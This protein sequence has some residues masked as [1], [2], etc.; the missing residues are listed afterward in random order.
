MDRPQGRLVAL[1]AAALI[2]T[3]TY[4]TT[5]FGL[6]VSVIIARSL[7]PKD[8]GQYA[9][10]LWMSGLLVV[11]GNHGLGIS[12]IRFVSESLGR[13]NPDEARNIHGWLRRQ[14]WISIMVVLVC[15]S[16][17]VLAFHPAGWQEHLALLIGVC[18]VSAIGKA[19]FLFDISIAKGYSRFSVEAVTNMVMSLLYTTG[20]AL[21]GLLHAS[22]TVFALFFALISAG[23]VVMVSRLLRKE[24][25]APGH[26]VCEPQVLARL[27]PHLLWTIVLVL[28]AT[29]SNKTIETFLLSTLIG[30]AAVGF[31]SIATALTRGGIDLLSSTLTTMLMPMMGHAY[32]A[33][34]MRKVNDIL[35]DAV[36]YFLFVGLIVAGLGVLWA[37]LGVSVMYGSRYEPVI[38]VLRVMM[39]V[40]GLTLAESAFGALLSTTDHQ[41]LRAGVSMLS[42]V[43]SAI[44]SLILVPLYGL[45]G[46]VLAHAVTRILVL[47]IMG[48]GLIRML[49]ITLPTREL[50][51]LMAAAAC[52]TLAIAPLLWISMSAW[53]QF[54]AGALYVFAFIAATV[55]LRAW[56]AKDAQ[57]ILTL[58]E[59]KPQY[60]GR[61]TPWLTRWTSSL[62]Q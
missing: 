39:L 60:F 17:S 3:S 58:L 42:V 12:G 30:P 40:G 25:I 61:I 52:A 48:G 19:I 1:K 18:I 24:G 45:S 10:L 32:G 29:L 28:V 43:V 22:L 44:A 6:I 27:K 35:S 31:F 33:G 49:H 41:K 13:G 21:L 38:N 55:A 53:M 56:Q 50:M 23:H 5:A 11:F 34:G 15:F 7:G 36:R 14:Q 20:V 51:R 57:L 8:Y 59:R 9:Y 26:G 47:I 62:P 54:F 46:A 16:G 2:A 4:V 37:E